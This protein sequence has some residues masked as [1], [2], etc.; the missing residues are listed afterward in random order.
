MYITESSGLEWIAL[1]LLLVL[2]DALQPV[3]AAAPAGA[4]RHAAAEIAH[5]ETSEREI[6]FH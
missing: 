5:L 1:E 6:K 4:S 3:G 2:G